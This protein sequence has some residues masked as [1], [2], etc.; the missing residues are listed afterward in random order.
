MEILSPYGKQRNGDFMSIKSSVNMEAAKA[1]RQA[2][3][4]ALRE[5]NVEALLAVANLGLQYKE[6]PAT[7]EQSTVGFGTNHD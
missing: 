7:V 3:K 6:T 4:L 2:R 1:L 5:N